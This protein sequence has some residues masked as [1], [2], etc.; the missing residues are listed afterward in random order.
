VAIDRTFQAVAEIVTDAV[1][2]A[3]SHGSIIYVNKGGE[4]LF[5]WDAQQLAGRPITVLLPD[6]FHDSARR[7][8]MRYI[9]IEPAEA[10]GNVLELLALHKDGHEFP[11]ELSLARWDD[12][13]GRYFTAIVRDVTE[14]KRRDEEL[15]AINAQLEVTNQELETFSYSVSH[16]LRAP[17]RAIDGFSAILEQDYAE[18]LDS[19]GR[20]CLNRVRAAAQRMYTLIDAL[21]TLSRVT[22]EEMRRDVID[23]SAL[24]RSVATEL[25][26]THPDRKV[27]FVIAPGIIGVGDGS[28]VRVA[29]ENLIGN[30]WKFTG[31]Q[32]K[33]RIEFGAVDSG[34]STVYYVR[35]NGA[36][37]DMAYVDKLFGAFQRLH[38]AEEFPGTGI[39][40]PTVQRIVRRH[41]GT[42]WAEAEVNEGATFWFTLA[43]PVTTEAA[44]LQY[45]M[46]G[47]Q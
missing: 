45:A 5:G 28:L 11:I 33:A 47:P 12:G 27:D 29:L 8:L 38:T 9:T 36:G 16:D 18:K 31:R 7:G 21:L 41:G 39:G 10:F 30:S 37:F 35:D 3:D 40:L 43:P 25:Q 17:I 13:P 1:I 23:L 22:R 19:R 15:R 44:P 32:A 2:S 20:D 14:R 4:R 42:V 46:R 6:R 24:A 26:R 34:G